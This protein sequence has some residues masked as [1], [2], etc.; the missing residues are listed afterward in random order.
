M[1]ERI[2]VGRATVR[3]KERREVRGLR[4]MRWGEQRQGVVE[5][6]RISGTSVGTAMAM[7]IRSCSRAARVTVEARV[8]SVGRAL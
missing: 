8:A 6:S 3:V 2:I 1:S 5:Q 7:G 4:K